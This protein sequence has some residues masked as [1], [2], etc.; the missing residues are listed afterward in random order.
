LAA[1]L[2]DDVMTKSH[3]SKGSCPPRFFVLFLSE[4]PLNLLANLQ[5]I[6]VGLTV[7]QVS[8]IEIAFGGPFPSRKRTE[9]YQAGVFSGVFTDLC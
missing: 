7:D 9:H 4:E 8:P 3:V 1:D 6:G 5:M 2:V